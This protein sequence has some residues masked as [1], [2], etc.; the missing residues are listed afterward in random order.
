M[1]ASYYSLVVSNWGFVR[2]LSLS[3]A[4]H[5][6]GDPWPVQVSRRVLISPRQSMDNTPVCV[7]VSPVAEEGYTM[8]AIATCRGAMRGINFSCTARGGEGK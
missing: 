3:L 1:T 5:S 2:S 6:M 8:P 7:C 4:L